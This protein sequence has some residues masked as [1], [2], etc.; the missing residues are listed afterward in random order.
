MDNKSYSRFFNIIINIII[1][2]L[3]LVIILLNI[4]LPYTIFMSGGSNNLT[5]IIN[6]EEEQVNTGEYKSLYVL[7]TNAN[8]ITYLLAKLNN[9]WDLIDNKD[10]SLNDDES[11]D[12]IY[13][14]DKLFLKKS[15]KDAIKIA[16][17]KANKKYEVIK[18]NIYIIGS[19]C[20]LKIGEKII[21]VDDIEINNTDDI[22]NIIENKN[23][24]DEV[25]VE[26]LYKN[27]TNKKS[28]KIKEIDNRKVLGIYLLN[29]EDIKIDPEIKFNFDEN[30]AGSSGGLMISLTIYDKLTEQDISNGR[31]ILGTGS[32]EE[33]GSVGRIDGLKY[34][35][36]GV[37]KEKYDVFFIPYENKE[38]ADEINKKYNL[39]LKYIPVRTF[40]EA[41]NYLINVK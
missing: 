39:K 26:T 4:K 18:N 6:V 17:L 3:V 10:Y 20:E 1:I 29:L 38:E 23:I 16:Y 15:I 11:Y 14:R 27:K 32:I 8:V 2:I 30:D 9:K 34:K 13:E 37:S 31:K 25:I 40:D 12:D 5:K 21:K 7:T 19:E 41:V 22:R 35:M 24:D 33:D 28:I 36:F